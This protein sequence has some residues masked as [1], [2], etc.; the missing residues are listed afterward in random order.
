MKKYV[1]KRCNEEFYDYISNNR[2][3]CSEACLKGLNKGKTY[4]DYLREA[5]IKKIKIDRL[6]YWIKI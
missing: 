1:C 4:E 2:K 5:G 3:F 6:N